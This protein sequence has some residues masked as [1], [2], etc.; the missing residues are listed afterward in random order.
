[1]DTVYFMIDGKLIEKFKSYEIDH[2]MFKGCGT[3]RAELAKPMSISPLAEVEVYINDTLEL[4]GILDARNPKDDKD[5]SSRTISGRDLMGVLADAHVDEAVTIKDQTLKQLADRLIGKLDKVKRAAIYY[6]EEAKTRLNSK[7]PSVGQFDS[8]LPHMQTE[9]GSSVFET[10]AQYARIKGLL[11]YSLPHGT[12]STQYQPVFVFSKARESGQAAFSLTRRKDGKGNNI[13]TS[14]LVQDDSK[15]YSQVTVMGQK[16]GVDGEAS[17]AW[18]ILAT[19]TDSTFPFYKPFV[20]KDDSGGDSPKQQARLILEKMRHDAFRLT[21]GVT[22][23][24]QN[25]KNWTINELCTV[26]DDEDDY[27]LY[28]DYL[29]YGRKFSMNKEQG[30]NTELRLGYKG[31]AA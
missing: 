29:I 12:G 28:D 31:M 20:L 7:G 9:M 23:H 21:Y 16:Q 13:N 24:S 22:G 3:F 14:E 18:N 30:Q 26:R 2:D 6:S 8:A 11:F 1:M 4:T 5:S 25:G 27:N 15:R 19:K 10:L 17:G